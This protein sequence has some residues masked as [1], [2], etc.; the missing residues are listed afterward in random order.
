M[1][2]FF[3]LKNVMRKQLLSIEEYFQAYKDQKK[4]HTTYI[5][6]SEYETIIL[7]LNSKESLDLIRESWEVFD[8]TSDERIDYR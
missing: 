8:H 2:L 4:N 3:R 5:T 6:F 7:S 1:K